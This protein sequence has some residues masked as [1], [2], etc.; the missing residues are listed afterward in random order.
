MLVEIALTVGT[1]AKETKS[2]APTPTS[3]APVYEKKSVS[4]GNGVSLDPALNAT[5]S[6]LTHL[7]QPADA[8]FVPSRPAGTA[9]RV[10]SVISAVGGSV[11]AVE[12]NSTDGDRTAQLPPRSS[13]PSTSASQCWLAAKL[14]AY[15]VSPAHIQLCEEKLV[16]QEGFTSAGLYAAPD[17]TTEL[18]AAY[19]SSLGITALG[20]QKALLHV[21][22]MLNVATDAFVPPV[23]SAQSA[24]KRSHSESQDGE[25]EVIYI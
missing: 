10:T 16:I 6:T 23:V 12:I 19:L 18:T 2:A 4:A 1:Q 15:G 20:L 22:A 5:Q 21:H 25:V 17:S 13:P 14:S 11:S 7:P 3:N 24:R 8:S 9:T